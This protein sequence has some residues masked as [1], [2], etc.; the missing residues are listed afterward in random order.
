MSF[1]LGP[2]AGSEEDVSRPEARTE[3]VLRPGA[4]QL[5]PLDGNLPA[6][7]VRAPHPGGASTVPHGSGLQESRVQRP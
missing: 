3:R 1:T 4:N 6:V 7:P 5:E 2:R